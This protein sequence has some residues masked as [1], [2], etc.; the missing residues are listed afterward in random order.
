MEYFQIEKGYDP[1][2]QVIDWMILLPLVNAEPGA[3]AG[4][5]ED[6]Q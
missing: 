1:E 4:D 3:Q 2:A 5:D 6:G